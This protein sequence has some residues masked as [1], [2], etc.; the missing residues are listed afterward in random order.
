TSAISGSSR[1]VFPWTSGVEVGKLDPQSMG[2]LR[3]NGSFSRREALASAGALV[4]AG[5]TAGNPALAASNRPKDEPFKF[6]LNTSTLG[7]KQPI[8]AVVDL[9]AKA[10]FQAMEP[11]IRELDAFVKAGG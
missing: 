1:R 7:W 5:L 8:D 10:G 3:M 11:W 4:A 6:C 9:M 2:E